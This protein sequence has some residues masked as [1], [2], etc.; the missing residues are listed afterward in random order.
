M[1]SVAVVTI[2]LYGPVQHV[3]HNFISLMHQ[4]IEEVD[5]PPERYVVACMFSSSNIR[6]CKLVLAILFVHFLVGGVLQFEVN[7][8]V[9]LERLLSM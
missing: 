7:G 3:G 6:E 2:V 1:Y 9:L 5:T 4:N 8:G